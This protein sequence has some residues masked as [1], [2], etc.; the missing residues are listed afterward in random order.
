MICSKR[1]RDTV[2]QALL[3]QGYRKARVCSPIG[4]DILAATPEGIA[5]SIVGEMIKSG[6]GTEP[7][8]AIRAGRC[9]CA[10]AGPLRP[11]SRTRRYT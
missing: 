2:H 5:V 6:P 3:E 10:V 4:I 8:L 11:E 1:K 9:C 7:L